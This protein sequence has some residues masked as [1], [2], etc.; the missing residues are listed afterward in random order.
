ME[1]LTI[2]INA[3]VNASMT[4]NTWKTYKTAVESFKT[5]RS[6]YQLRDV[7]PAPLNDVMYYIAYLS[8]TGLSAFTILTY[9]SGLSY[10]H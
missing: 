4:Q 2:E 5:C 3:L 6:L 7:W 8:Y 9:I 10:T 1:I